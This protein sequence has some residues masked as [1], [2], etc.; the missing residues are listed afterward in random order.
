MT[1]K[2]FVLIAALTPAA[3]FLAARSGA[4][5]DEVLSLALVASLAGAAGLLI[6]ELEASGDD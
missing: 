3:G 6:R 2:H 4:E 1:L 5:E